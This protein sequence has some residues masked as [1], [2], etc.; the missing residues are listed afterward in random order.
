M[1]RLGRRLDMNPLCLKCGVAMRFWSRA[2]A[3][4]IAAARLL[5]RRRLRCRW[6]GSCGVV[7][8]RHRGNRLNTGTSHRQT[9]NG[10]GHRGTRG[11]EATTGSAT[12][13]GRLV[14][15]FAFFILSQNCYGDTRLQVVLQSNG[16]PIAVAQNAP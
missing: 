4:A 13:K 16:R 9:G 2:R 10:F 1:G 14:Q 3:Y 8:S 11:D 12:L 5:G 7:S 6:H 15:C